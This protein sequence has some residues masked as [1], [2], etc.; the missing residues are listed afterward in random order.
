VRR[1]N[2]LIARSSFLF[3]PDPRPISRYPERDSERIRWILERR[4]PRTRLDP[5]RASASLIEE[6]R[7]ETGEVVTSATV[8]LTNRECPWRCLMCDLWQH[9]LEESVPVGAIPTQIR[10]AL[11]RLLPARRIKLYNAGSFFDPKAIPPADHESIAALLDRF[12]RVTVECHPALVGESCLRFHDLLG[13]RLEVAL[14][15]ETIHPAVLPRLNK[16]MTLEQFRR[17]AEGLGRRGIPLRSFVLVGLPFIT[18]VDSVEWCGRSVDFAFDCGSSVVSL[19]PTRAGNGA[20]DALA[21]TGDFLPPTLGM[22][23]ETVARGVAL[24]RGRVFADLWD[25]AR[26]K[27]CGDCFEARVSRLRKINLEQ[28]VAAPLSCAACGGSR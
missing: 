27:D 5:L 9:T 20:L 13:G 11:A 3:T 12:E 7:T 15:L 28:R 22:L 6:E 16:G 2:P 23:E 14:G 21:G 8:F 25:L 19:I 1:A 17:A 26:L 24:R 18:S 10:E 4:G